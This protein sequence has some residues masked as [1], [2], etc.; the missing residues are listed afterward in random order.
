MNNHI[1]PVFANKRLK[2]I[3]KK[4]V[5][6]FLCNQPKLKGSSCKKLK[7]IF[8]SVFSFAVEE[9]IVEANPCSKARHKKDTYDKT[10]FKFLTKE[11]AMKLLDLTAE[12]SQLNIITRILLLTGMRIGE[13]LSL[14]TDSLDIDHKIIRVKSTLSYANNEWFISRP[15]TEDSER[16]LKVNQAII[17]MIQEHLKHQE[18]LKEI[19]GDAWEKPSLIFTTPTGGFCDRTT[20]NKQFKSL[21]EKNNLPSISLHG[22]RHTNASLL[23]YM[24]NDVKRV[25]TALGHSQTQITNDTYVHVFDEYEARMSDSLC[26]NLFRK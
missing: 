12:Y 3:R 26:D 23:I 1:L 11:Q 19:V 6:I 13:V 17:D 22:L 18:K 24:G 9:G 16:V 8:S 4:D 20:I 2:D 15:K 7:I 21:L 14:E 5:Q 25:S 10:K